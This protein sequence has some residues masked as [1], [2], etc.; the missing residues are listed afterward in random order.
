[1]RFA[2]AF[3]AA[4]IGAAPVA[5]L[6]TK[7]TND[8]SRGVRMFATLTELQAKYARG[9]IAQA[10]KERLGAQG[11]RAGIATALVESTLI[12]HANYA[13]PDSLVYDY[14]R[15]GYDRDSVGL[16]QQRASIYTDI[17]CSM[18]AAC[19][20]HQFFTEMK[21]VPEWRY[22]DVGTL[23]QEVQRSENPEQYHE[24]IDQAVD[25][26]KEGGF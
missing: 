5:A 4:A 25:I 8:A 3:A 13:V 23:C 26:C 10:K 20:A 16:F 6:P 18:N 14:D 11:C 17:K 15:L 2:A 24:F 9:I 21:G 22:M 1:M 12:M 19:S 7:T